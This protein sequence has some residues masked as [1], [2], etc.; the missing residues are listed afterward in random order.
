MLFNIV[1]EVLGRETSVEKEIKDIKTGKE[2]VKLSIFT[3]DM[4]L[5]MEKPKHSTK[6]LWELINQFNKVAGCKMIIQNQ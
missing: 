6:K 3:D 4:I 1:L 5:Y 2:E